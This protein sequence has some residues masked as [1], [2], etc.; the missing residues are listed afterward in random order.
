MTIIVILN[1]PVKTILFNNCQELLRKNSLEVC[2]RFAI[3]YNHNMDGD[4]NKC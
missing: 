3:L 1:K 2:E 4:E